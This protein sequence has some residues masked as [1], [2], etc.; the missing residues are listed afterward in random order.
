MYN[1]LTSVLTQR[2]KLFQRFDASKV[3]DD[4]IETED[5]KDSDLERLSILPALIR[6]LCYDKGSQYHSLL[7]MRE[8]NNIEEE[9][10]RILTRRAVKII[11][12]LTNC[13]VIIDGI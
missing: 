11:Q 6:K 9:N 8:K 12:I 5:F 2:D 1:N 10:V 7:I 4:D 13:D 3:T